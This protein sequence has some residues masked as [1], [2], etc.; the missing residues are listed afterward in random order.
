MLRV[1]AVKKRRQSTAR[2]PR[3]VRFT[4]LPF[5]WISALRTARPFDVTRTLKQVRRRTSTRPGAIRTLRAGFFPFFVAVERP[6]GR[7]Q[8]PASSTYATA[9]WRRL[10]LRLTV[11]RVSV[12]RSPPRA[13]RP[14]SPP[15]GS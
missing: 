13:A 7:P 14:P 9:K 10:A 11:V 2:P 1:P 8:L 5:R 12:P 4:P 15:P 3:S 6:A